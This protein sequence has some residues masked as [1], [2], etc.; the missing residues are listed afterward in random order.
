MPESTP[1]TV[2]PDLVKI[3]QLKVKP[4]LTRMQERLRFS[5]AAKIPAQRLTE[6]AEMVQTAA[7]PQALYKTSRITARSAD[8]LTIDRVR[9]NRPLLKVNLAKA[10]H[11]WPFA[12]T[13]GADID[14]LELTGQGGTG[15]AQAAANKAE[16]YV[17]EIVKEQLL[18]ATLRS[19]GD[20]LTGRFHLNY[21]WSLICG[22]MEAWPRSEN[23]SVLALLGDIREQSG[24]TLQADYSLKPRYSRSGLFYYVETEFEGCQVCAKEPCMM[25]RAQFNPELAAKP[26]LKVNKVCGRET[27]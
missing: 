6:L 14:R 7:R 12:A 5:T 11:I 21:I 17:L 8:G 3:D 22:E 20:H 9:I 13:L 18:E 19:L 27:D 23:Q 2:F 1:K 25:R 24:I 15:D 26:G 4:D 16:N 10:V